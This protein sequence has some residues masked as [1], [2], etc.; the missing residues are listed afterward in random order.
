MEYALG[1]VAENSPPSP[2]FLLFLLDMLELFFIE[3]EN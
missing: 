3:I 2:T 1:I